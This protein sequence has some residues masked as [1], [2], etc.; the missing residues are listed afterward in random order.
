MSSTQ[1]E[2]EM[3][4]P[5][6]QT[7]SAPTAVESGSNS[8]VTLQPPS[9]AAGVQLQQPSPPT[10]SPEQP[11]FTSF[12]EGEGPMNPD[13]PAEPMLNKL[14]NKVL[15]LAN[16]GKSPL[17]SATPSTAPSEIHSPVTTEIKSKVQETT[18]G[19]GIV[20]NP[21]QQS[22]APSV[23]SV[24]APTETPALLSPNPS[25]T[26]SEK[27]EATSTRQSIIRPVEKNTNV[28]KPLVSAVHATAGLTR[29]EDEF[30]MGRSGESEKN[31]GA[32][33][34]E[35]IGTKPVPLRAQLREIT[36]PGLA[37]FRLMREPS[38]DSE[39]VSSY[40][41][42]PARTAVKTIIGRLKSGD[43]GREFWMKD[44]SSHE[45]FLCGEKFTSTRGS[46]V[47]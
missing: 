6:V 27:P 5:T 35:S 25:S 11:S 31:G 21:T 34:N 16:S 47:K 43:L 29:S 15:S 28:L 19:L 2:G 22:K 10:H 32:T 17:S 46:R 4:L 37:G 36:L 41:T 18:T 1:T 12:P 44:E 40:S 33:P 42:H 13:I 20:L 7:T 24:G 9:L 26:A 8:S 30:P 3:A 23:S 45:C 14:Y 39:S 38:S